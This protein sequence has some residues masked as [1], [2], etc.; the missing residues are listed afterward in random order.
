MIYMGKNNSCK[1]L[2]HIWSQSVIQLTLKLCI[3]SVLL[4]LFSGCGTCTC[5]NQRERV[6]KLVFALSLLI[7][8]D[9]GSCLQT[10]L[11]TCPGKKAESMKYSDMNYQNLVGF[12]LCIH[13]NAPNFSRYV[14]SFLNGLLRKQVFWS[15]ILIMHRHLQAHTHHADSS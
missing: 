5:C 1:W 11:W 2:M 7:D 15:T 9:F 12:L 4:L 13:F 6:E 14:L 3:G 8:L 10:E